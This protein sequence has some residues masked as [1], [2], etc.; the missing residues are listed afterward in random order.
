MTNEEK[1]RVLSVNFAKYE[2]KFREEIMIK[3]QRY[4]S[5]MLMAEW[6]DK[7]F[8]DVIKRLK[9][10]YQLDEQALFILNLV[11]CRYNDKK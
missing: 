8:S 9:E 11:E 1:A 2:T 6:K 5:A 7:C 4:N 10:T 3:L